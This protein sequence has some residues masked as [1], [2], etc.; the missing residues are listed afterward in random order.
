LKPALSR[1]LYLVTAIV[2]VAAAAVLIGWHLTQLHGNYSAGMLLQSPST[3]PSDPPPGWLSELFLKPG[4]VQMILPG[5]PAEAA[6]IGRNDRV[7]AIGGIPVE[8]Q[9]RILKLDRQVRPGDTVTYTVRSGGRARTVPLRLAPALAGFKAWFAVVSDLLVAAAFLAVGFLVFTR[10]AEDLRARLFFLFSVSA[11]IS[12]LLLPVILQP[13]LSPLGLSLSDSRL[14]SLSWIPV[15]LA[16]FVLCMTLL[17]LSMVFPKPLRLLQRRPTLARWIYSLPLAFLSTLFLSGLGVG[18]LE[19]FFRDG[20]K[21]FGA[22][23]G[24]VLLIPAALLVRRLYRRVRAAGRVGAWLDY[25]GLTLTAATLVHQALFVGGIGLLLWIGVLDVIPI[26]LG[27]FLI[28]GATLGLM[29]TPLSYTGL[30]CAALVAGYRQA[31]P[32]EKR[33]LRWPLWGTIVALSGTV[34]FGLFYYALA[35]LP[36]GGTGRYI[37]SGYLV[38]KAFYVLIPISFAVGIFKYRLMD[39][40]VIIRKTVIYSAVTGILIVT[41]FAQAAVAGALLV[42]LAGV[43]SVWGIVLAT[44]GAAALLL[45][46]HGRVQ[47][48]VD[49]RFFKSKFDYPQALAAMERATAEALDRAVVIRRVA[50]T[51]QAATRCRALAVFL[52]AE[53][54]EAYRTVDTIGLPDGWAQRM[55]LVPEPSFAAAR[56]V[57]REELAPEAA[58]QWQ[59]LGLELAAPVRIGGAAGGLLAVGRR[60]PGRHLEEEDVD[61]LA[62][63][64]DVLGDG[65]ARLRLRQQS[66]DLELARDIQRRLLPQQIPVRPGLD[67]AAAW[68][69]SRWVGGDYYDVIELGDGRLGL[70]IAD[71][72]GKGMPAAL[73]MSNQQAALRALAGVGLPPREVCERLNRTLHPQMPA[74]RFITLFYAE[75]D[76][77]SHRLTYVNA[78]HC[79]PLLVRPDGKALR[80]EE[81]GL[82]LGVF[83]N[84]GYAQADVALAAGD[85]LVLYTDGVAEAEDTRLEQFGEDR[86]L[87][88]ARDGRTQPPLELVR[89]I[90]AAVQEHCNGEPQDDLTLMVLAVS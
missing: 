33:Q 36:I 38:S 68:Q 17:H 60:Q 14:Y 9:E 62:Q 23:A 52:Q 50:E 66:Q 30:A 24:L 58:R 56:V 21:R 51:V 83:P 80:L 2:L 57:R 26:V 25:P 88:L 7:V 79:P 6:G 61:F 73:L 42:L 10:R 47:R 64:A 87:E 8:E 53:A 75:Y 20:M 39:I 45:P 5:S 11:G 59:R 85:V 90:E 13:V 69:P 82:I 81:G 32:E 1:T 16:T 76:P 31:G 3:R 78:G 74:G 41:F 15:F 49:R 77:A 18:L 22:V 27:V 34:L 65:L 54:G 40:D 89:R 48:F 12:Y 70:A 35:L 29:A 67:I 55:A 19:G 71:V 63:A 37:G 28:G 86:L 4:T 84:R 44:L 46:L 43:E 72:A